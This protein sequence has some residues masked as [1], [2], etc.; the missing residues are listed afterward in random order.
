LSVA[1]RA[2]EVSSVQVP[3]VCLAV[4]LGVLAVAMAF[5]KLPKV[6]AP[7]PDGEAVSVR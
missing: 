5:S 7:E 2:A 6:D 4:T 3:Y 1:D